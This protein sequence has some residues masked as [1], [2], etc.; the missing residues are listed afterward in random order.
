MLIATL[1]SIPPRFAKIGATLECLKRQ[2]VP[3]DRIILYIPKNYARFPNW[4]GRLPDVPNGVQIRRCETDLGPATKVLPAVRDFAGQNVQLLLCD[5]DRA[6]TPEWS[7]RLL[8]ASQTKPKAAV[9]ALGLHSE[10]VDGASTQRSLKPR[11]IRRWRIT[12][13]EF[14]LRFFAKQ[15]AAGRSWRDV[16]AP[17]RRVFCRSGYVDIFEGCGGVLLRPEMFDDLAF[18]IPDL[19]WSVDDVWLSGMLARQGVPIWVPANMYEP[20]HTE[21]EVFDPLV[22]SSVGGNDRNSANRAA[23]AYLRKTYGIWSS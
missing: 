1:S 18:D 3:F 5:D 6:Y 2:S 21:A 22:T 4:D 7:T 9:A 17:H 14:Q 19:A 15:I 12:D 8:R 16:Q 13:V 10:W 23:V 11:A 20:D